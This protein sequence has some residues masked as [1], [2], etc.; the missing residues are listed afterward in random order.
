MKLTTHLITDDRL[1]D[2]MRERL[3]A[4]KHALVLL[5]DEWEDMLVNACEAGISEL[6]L[7]R[8]R[9]TDEI[10]SIWLDRD[11]AQQRAWKREKDDIVEAIRYPFDM[12]P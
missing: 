4:W 2:T 7:V 9:G 8:E 3:C 10:E 12:V 11:A 1:P 6:W 5:R